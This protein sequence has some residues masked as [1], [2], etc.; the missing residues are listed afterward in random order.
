M[1]P[2]RAFGW[3]IPAAGGAALAIAAAVLFAP[4]F[5][6][7]SIIIIGGEENI[8][9]EVRAATMKFLSDQATLARAPRLFLVPRAALA[10]LLTERFPTLATVQILRRL[11][12]SLELHLQERVPVA[13]LESQ[14]QRFTI[15]ADG[16]V[17]RGDVSAALKADLP[18]VRADRAVP[19]PRDRVLDP[20]VMK[21]LHEVI[22]RLP[23]ELA[24]TVDHL[25][26]ASDGSAD[27][28]VVTSTGWAL[29]FDARRPLDQQLKALE[30]LV[31]D[32]IP[33][34]SLTRLESVDLRIAGKIYYRVRSP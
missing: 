9:E 31:R 18:V 6:V 14:G 22:V 13:L 28:Q 27:I 15:D 24:V 19:R 33:A 4:A 20:A 30:T 5:R 12:G 10:H 3:I 25:E 11:P 1:F 8:H 7:T 26:I 17:I 16:A 29:L 34:A 21:I 2:W 32:T 23:E